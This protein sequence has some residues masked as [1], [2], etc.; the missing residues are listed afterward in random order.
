[1]RMAGRIGSGSAAPSLASGR[2]M[3]DPRSFNLPSE[4]LIHN[5][6][7]RADG[8]AAAVQRRCEV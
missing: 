4:A 7:F 6:L 1:M 2:V 3:D 5:R 8:R